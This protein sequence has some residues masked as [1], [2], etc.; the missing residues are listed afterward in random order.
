MKKNVHN[1]LTAAA[2]GLLVSLSPIVRASGHQPDPATLQPTK[3][4][5]RI[6]MYRVKNSLTMNLLIEKRLGDQ[7]VVML[8]DE[9]GRELHRESL[10]RRQQKYARLLNFAETVDGTYTVVVRNGAE[11]ITRQIRLSTQTLYEMPKRLLIAKD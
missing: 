9:R 5:F 8:L 10:G 7:L 1:L 11:E 6:G 2:F 4:S 3:A